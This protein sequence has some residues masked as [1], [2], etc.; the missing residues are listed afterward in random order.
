MRSLRIYAL[1]N[2]QT[3]HTAVLTWELDESGQ[4]VQ[5][6]SYKISKYQGYNVQH[7]DYS[8]DLLNYV[9]CALKYEVHETL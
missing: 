5:T 9:L 4:K 6:S 1:N 8:W 3:Y 7:D 2:F